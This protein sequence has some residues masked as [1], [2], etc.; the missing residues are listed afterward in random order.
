MT[1]NERLLAHALA[2]LKQ[3]Q[4]A[5]EIALAALRQAGEG[6]LDGEPM[7]AFNER[8]RLI[9]CIESL[10]S[11]TAGDQGLYC[12]QEHAHDPA[13]G[14]MSA[15]VCLGCWNKLAQEVIELRKQ[16]RP[17]VEPSV[18]LC[19]TCPPAD[20]PINSIR[21]ASCPRRT[22][23]AREPHPHVWKGTAQPWDEYCIVCGFKPS[24]QRPENGSELPK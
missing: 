13:D 6:Y 9:E 15:A 8:V 23:K 11:E 1:S 7:K 21:C 16:V 20:Q 17:A 14:P 18:T 3:Q 4:R 24:P 10:P 5:E 22:V 12:E 19:A 2:F